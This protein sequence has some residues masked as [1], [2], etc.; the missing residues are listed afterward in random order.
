MGIEVSLI[1]A[2][3]AMLCWGIGDFLIQRSTRKV[4][5]IEAL[6]FI[7]VIGTL[8]LFPFVLKDLDSLLSLPNILLLCFLGAV[9]FLAAMFDFEALKKGK[10]SVIEVIIELEL[11]ITIALGF[12]FFKERLSLLQ[13]AVISFIFIGIILIATKSFKHL[14]IKFEKGIVIALIAAFGM[15][16][17][18]FLTAA[19]S[20]QIS[21]IM[22]VWFP[23][24]IFSAICF[25]V[26]VREKGISKTIKN[27]KKFKWLI[28]AMGIFDTF[29]W[30][31][32]ANAVFH[33]EISIITA[34]TESYPA[35]GMVLGV[36]I[37]KEKIRWHQWTGA[38]I[39]FLCSLVLAFIV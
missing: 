19:S 17:I 22:A 3:A 5:D 39:A 13:F 31:F 32:Y 11:P 35:V 1:F 14:R 38:A 29:A 15:G 34:I 18:N 25:F 36:W 30:I 12:I 6:A 4:G 27:A 16:L 7:G 37:N 24:V 21:P 2:F 10:L 28:L 20:K 26:L 33:E 9:T 23:W 8:M